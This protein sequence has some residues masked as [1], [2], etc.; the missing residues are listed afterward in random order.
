MITELAF[1]ELERSGRKH[2]K[3]LEDYKRPQL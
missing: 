3:E 1:S 2:Q